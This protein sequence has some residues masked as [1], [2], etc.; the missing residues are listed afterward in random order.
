MSRNNLTISI[1]TAVV[2]IWAVNTI[3]S[4]TRDKILNIAKPALKTSQNISY[5]IRSVVLPESKFSR[6]NRLL[7]EQIGV[8]KNRLAQLDEI[9]SENE[10]LKKLLGFKRDLSYK[11]ISAKVI[12]RDPSNWTSIIY[13]DKGKEDRIKKYMAVFADKGLIGRVIEAGPSSA[14]VMFITDPDSSI[15]VVI[16]RTRYDGLLYGTLTRQC[17]MV[18]LSLNADVWPGDLVV[19]SGM[20]ETIPKGLLVGTVED[21]FIDKS[22]LYQTAIVKPAV[23]F[24]KIEEV[25]CIE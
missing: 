7:R 23:D 5:K 13:I 25:L 1:L 3:F 2:L 12:G 22:R 6:E 11:S 9:A 15:G 4:A 16:Q 10:R 21:V 14:K 8:L 20:G 18:Y 17:Q 24:S 19:T